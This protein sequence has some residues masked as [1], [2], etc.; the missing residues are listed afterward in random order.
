MVMFRWIDDVDDADVDAVAAGLDALPD[1]IPSIA[2]YH[3]GRD[4]GVNEGNFD[5][6]VV[7][8]FVSIGDYLTYR[9]HPAHRTF[10]AEH[11][12]GRV[13]DRAALQ[14]ES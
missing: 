11:I 8:E 7:A 6:G 5:Y 13:A 3:H 9:D 14:F 12:T 10:I 2:S 4:L 1:Q